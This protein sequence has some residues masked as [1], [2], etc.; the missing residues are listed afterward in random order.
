MTKKKTAMLSL[1]T[2]TLL[3]FAVAMV[4]ASVTYQN[5]VG[6]S[7]SVNPGV[8][9]TVSF[10]LKND[11]TGDI[12]NLV[13][14][15]PVS[16]SGCS[17]SFDI[18]PTISGM[19][20]TLATSASS[21]T[22][23]LVFTVPQNQVACSS[24]TAGLK[25]RGTYTNN[26]GPYTLP[27]SLGVNA[28]PSLEVTSSLS[29]LTS[30][31]TSTFTITNNG[32]TAVSGINVNVDALTYGGKTIT[33]TASPSTISSLGP[34]S[35]QTVELSANIPTSEESLLDGATTTVRVTATGI[36]EITRQLSVQSSYCEA[37]DIGDLEIDRI[38]FTNNGNPFAI[39]DFGDKN[40]WFLT[41]EIEVEVR[42]KNNN[43]DE[44]IRDVTV[45]WGLYDI[46]T[47]EFIMDDEENSFNLDASG[48]SN[49][50][51]TITFTF[52]LDPNDFDSDFSEGDFEFFVKAYSDDLGEDNQC[53]SIVNSEVNIRKDNDFVVLNNIVLLSDSIPCN[54]LLEGEFDVWN[55]GDS[56]EDDVSV[57]IFNNELGID[58][59]IAIG[60]LDA[61]EDKSSVRFSYPIPQNAA[62]KS[63]VLNFEVLDEYGDIFQ[64]DDDDEAEFVSKSFQV[65]GSCQAQQ[66]NV[67]IN[68]LLDSETPSAVP[69]QQ[70]IV[71]AT[72]RNL[73]NTEATYTVS[74][75]GNTGWSNLISVSPNVVTLAAGES[76]VVNIVLKINDDATGDNEFTINAN[77][78]GQITSQKVVLSISSSS[79][80]PT[81]LGPFAQ[82][83]KDNWFIYLIILVNL[84]LIIAI[85]LVVRRM[86]S[87]GV[88]M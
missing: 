3:I 22:V 39:N 13:F 82:N 35:S 61:L 62:E 18:T 76:K 28:Q 36:T 37:G 59:E 56:D 17:N 43:A 52:T 20:S 72:L 26:V 25:L 81:N 79:G 27:L 33:V 80:Q 65:S 54:G 30:S 49:D 64:N 87:P 23:T 88:P 29:P 10:N 83:I 50:D 63:Y 71:E 32:N 34:G 84:I 7:Q 74:V 57:R 47:G 11:N 45:A 69:G 21:G 73:G 66:G 55:I 60:S 86:L 70:V 42:V 58:D 24:Y 31:Q 12:T 78:N 4:S 77:N 68:A 2:A 5:V 44:K 8:S 75:E 9:V 1:I 6:A 14:D 16:F 48:K 38:K 15:T 40:D 51:K 67:L 41:D 53:N 85:I 46:S 19:P